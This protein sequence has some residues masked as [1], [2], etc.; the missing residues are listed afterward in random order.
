MV[1]LGMEPSH[2]DTLA[3]ALF[4]SVNQLMEEV[5]DDD[6]VLEDQAEPA[7]P[8]A[9][10]EEE[11][12]D[13]LALEENPSE[14]AAAAVPPPPAAAPAVSD[15]NKR[16]AERVKAQG[17]DALKAGRLKDA[18]TLYGQAL[19]LN[20]TE[21]VYY[22]NRSSVLI[23]LQQHDAALRDAHECVRLRPEW[24][25]S[26]LRVGAALSEMKRHAEAAVA[27]GKALRLEPSNRQIAALEEAAKIEAES[28]ENQFD[29]L[30]VGCCRL[31][32][33]AGCCGCCG[34]VAAAGCCG[35]CGLAAAAAAAAGCS[36]A[37]RCCSLLLAAALCCSLLLTAARCG[38]C[39]NVSDGPC[40][41]RLPSAARRSSRSVYLRM[42]FMSEGCS[43][44]MTRR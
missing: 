20:P 26:H 8:E 39:P 22:S 34:L 5:E 32:A 44:R 2:V 19:A 15:A 31:A 7:D 21:A 43:C 40:C 12:D 9:A 18:A 42:T 27:Y 4:W 36:L 35:C 25:K 24:A 3:R 17:N 11:S 14:A 41:R 6:L 10:A 13:E 28:A 33:A 29:W 16:A 1:E 23:S 30:Q 37:A 38:S